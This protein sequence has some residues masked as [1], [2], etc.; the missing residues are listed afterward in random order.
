MDPGVAF[1]PDSITNINC[2]ACVFL[3]APGD[4]AFQGL[5]GA[6]LGNPDGS[7]VSTVTEHGSAFLVPM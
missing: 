4:V 3:L 6:G 1:S 2:G 7:C 5:G